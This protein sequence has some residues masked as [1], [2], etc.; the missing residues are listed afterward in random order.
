MQ[1]AS[2]RRPMSHPVAAVALLPWLVFYLFLVLSTASP[3]PQKDEITYRLYANNL[4]NAEYAPEGTEFLW[5]GPGYPLFLA[6]LL[7]GENVVGSSNIS[8]VGQG[9]TP[10]LAA[11][12]ANAF[13]LY[14]AIFNLYVAVRR[15]TPPKIAWGA[16]L[17][18]ALFWP[19]YDWIEFTM[20]EVFTVFLI[21]ALVNSASYYFTTSN[22]IILS[23]ILT[24]VLGAW[25]ALTKVM[26]GYVLMS[27]LLLSLVLWLCG[28]RTAG[29]CAQLT[30]LA[31]LFCAPYLA[32]TQQ[33]TGKP[34]LWGTSGGMQ[35]YW[36]SSP[37]EQNR[38]DWINYIQSARKDASLNNPVIR[39]HGALFSEALEYKGFYQSEPWGQMIKRLGVKQDAM[40]KTAAWQNII[41]HPIKYLHNWRDN[42]GRLMWDAPY[43]FRKSHSFWRYGVPHTLLLG[44]IALTLLRVVM[45]QRRHF[46]GKGFDS[47]LPAAVIPL[48]LFALCYLSG[49]SL[50]SAYPRQFYIL[51]PLLI[52]LCAVSLSATVARPPL[53][54]ERLSVTDAGKL[55]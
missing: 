48:A 9:I 26:F 35:L 23:F 7:A 21:S 3:G 41:S 8:Q 39:Q 47:A 22:R 12:I 46:S 4:L 45:H 44:L 11:Q 28:S 40:F 25:L 50:V 34:F 15:H 37:F 54:L 36:M 16:S 42:I 2:Y 24:A 33:L 10:I 32:Y 53:A 13:L 14:L 17:G 18:L 52:W 20:S 43:S 6:P 49:T 29:R 19:I 51:T 38:G 1:N 31:L 30:M 55:R 5:A 27:C